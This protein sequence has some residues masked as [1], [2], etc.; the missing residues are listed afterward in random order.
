MKTT[1]TTVSAA[2]LAAL[3]LVTPPAGAAV[4]TKKQAPKTNPE[5]QRLM[6][7]GLGELQRGE[8]TAA[9][10]SLN[11]A[12]RK[13]GSVS[14]YFLLGW[15]H[16]QRGFKLGSVETADRDDAQS[17]IDAYGMA[18]SK[19]PE[20]SGLPDPSRLYFSLALCEEAVESYD[21]ALEAYKSALRAAPG[22]ALIPL[23]AARLRLKMKDESKALSNLSMAVE[24]AN[25]TG[26][27]GA[28]IAAV[29]HDP[30]FAPL[31]ANRSM[32]RMLGISA[33]AASAAAVAS[34]A[35]FR[36]EEMRDAV[37]DT[38][39]AV[40]S[41][42]DPAVLDKV[43]AGNAEFKFRRYPSAV[44]AYNEALSLNMERST[45][46]NDQVAALYEKIGT[47]YNKVGQSDQAVR[48]LQKSLQM[49]PMNAGA[50]YQIALAYAMSGKTS[51]ALHALKESF[52]T[53]GD[54]AELRRLVLLAKTDVELEAVRDLPAYPQVVADVAD[55]V[56]L[57]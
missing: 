47:A 22:K 25:K 5:A 2:V 10:T 30:S 55:R 50:H 11:K 28:L 9:I 42:Q 53:A 49:N 31:L 33:P 38:P 21:R 27:E 18:L 8:Y 51:E 44:A 32:R 12:V 19:D 57:R 6:S 45:L 39:R 36:N 41:A 56:A 54:P 4:K 7:Q 52:S 16:Y 20:L 14:T 29:Q 13:E 15:A 46:T 23:H 48:S 1:M 35:D 24:K 26:R 43:A 34:N 3:L 37:R 17:A 40:A